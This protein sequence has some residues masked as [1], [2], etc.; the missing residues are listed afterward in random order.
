MGCWE[1]YSPPSHCLRVGRNAASRL[2]LTI[3]L[4]EEKAFGCNEYLIP[5]HQS[6]WALFTLSFFFFFFKYFLNLDG[7]FWGR[8]MRVG[9]LVSCNWVWGVL[10]CFSAFI[11]LL[12]PKGVCFGLASRPGADLHHSGNVGL[13]PAKKSGPSSL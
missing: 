12:I 2:T 6:V 3:T 8:K 4:G 13:K 1:A 10:I 11:A 5:S 9:V 7:F